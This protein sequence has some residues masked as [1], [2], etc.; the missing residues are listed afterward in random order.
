MARLLPAGLLA[1]AAVLLALPAGAE[2]YRWTDL[3]GHE[4]FTMNLHRVPP[5]HRAEAERRAVLEKARA[6]P[7]ADAINTMTTPDSIKVKRALR[8]RSGRA[9]AARPVAGADGV[10]SS[11]HRRKA[12]SLQRTVDGWAKKLELEEQLARRL[13]RTEA[14]LRAENRAERYEIYLEQAEQ[15]QEDFEDRMRQQGVLPGCYR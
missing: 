3:A 13:V 6:Q 12:Q 8:P 9:R 11:S 4:H 5:E 7:A 10:C 2:I 1:A 15:A 14:R